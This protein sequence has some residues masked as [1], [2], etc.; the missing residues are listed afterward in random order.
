MMSYFYINSYTA[1]LSQQSA[2]NISNTLK[3]PL[4]FPGFFF[5]NHSHFIFLAGD[6]NSV[7][8]NSM[9]L[10][11]VSTSAMRPTSQILNDV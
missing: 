10:S 9:F 3:E 2:V 5:F 7:P 1:S 6:M 11:S 8:Y 4:I